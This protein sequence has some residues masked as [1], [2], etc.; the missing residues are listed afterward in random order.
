MDVSSDQKNL[1]QYKEKAHKIIYKMF[2]VL[3]RAHRKVSDIE[4]RKVLDKLN[5]L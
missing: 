5:Q 4:Y 1:A 3:M 2:N